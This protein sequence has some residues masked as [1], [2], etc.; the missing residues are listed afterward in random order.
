MSNGWI[1]AMTRFVEYVAWSDQRHNGTRCLVWTRK[2]N[3]K[4]YARFSV[5]GRNVMVHRWIY[6]KWVGPIPDGLVIDHLCRNRRCV[7]PAHM[8][9]VTNRQ[10]IL[11]GVGPTA[12][13]ARKTECAHGHPYDEVNTGWVDGKRYCRV[14]RSIVDRRTRQRRKAAAQ[15]CAAGG[16]QPRPRGEAPLDAP[17]A[18]NGDGGGVVAATVPPKDA[19]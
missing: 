4:G 6:E 5:A 18:S 2:T 8:E 17:S 11:R 19:A 14:C 7:N 16:E 13:N 12:V 1:P 3:S 9:P 15:S 10:N